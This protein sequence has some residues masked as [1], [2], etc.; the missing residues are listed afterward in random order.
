MTE[1]WTRGQGV[2]AKHCWKKTRGR[3]EAREQATRRGK[4]SSASL[5]RTQGS[6][7]ART[8]ST[9]GRGYGNRRARE[10]TR[11]TGYLFGPAAAALNPPFIEGISFLQLL[12]QLHSVLKF[13]F[14]VQRGCVR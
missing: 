1:K 6:K 9:A 10:E 4:E 5:I 14:R 13:R 11:T 7:R 3:E 8:G 12:P 2:R